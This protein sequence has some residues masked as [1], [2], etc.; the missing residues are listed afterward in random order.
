MITMRMNV[1]LMMRITVMIVHLEHMIQIM[2]VQIMKV[3]VYV[4]MVMMMMTM[5]VVLMM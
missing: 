2:M 1:H 5:M 3:M 4:M